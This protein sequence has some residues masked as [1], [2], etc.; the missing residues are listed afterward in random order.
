MVTK[1]NELNKQFP[2]KYENK[3]NTESDIFALKIFHVV[4]RT[5]NLE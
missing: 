2:M 5:L 3:K 1:K 4:P